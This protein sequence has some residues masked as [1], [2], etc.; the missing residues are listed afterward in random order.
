MKRNT[1]NLIESVIV[2]L[3]L[4][5]TAIVFSVSTL[6]CLA[7]FLTYANTGES[8]GLAWGFGF[9]LSLLISGACFSACSD[10]IG[11]MSDITKRAK[12]PARGS[13]NAINKEISNAKIA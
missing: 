13:E 4:M 9:L 1:K 5:P 3:A 8:M 6:V 10:V 7:V 12:N 2:L 11:V